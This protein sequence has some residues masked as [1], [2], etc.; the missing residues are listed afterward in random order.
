TNSY[1]RKNG[2]LKFMKRDSESAIMKQ[3]DFEEAYLV[4]FEETFSHDTGMPMVLTITL[5][6]R[7]MKI[8]DATHENEWIK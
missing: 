3:V 6:A 8:G 7:K 4:S 2:A 5:S 1:D